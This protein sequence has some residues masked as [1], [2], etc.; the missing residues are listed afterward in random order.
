MESRCRGNDGVALSSGWNESRLFVR[1]AGSG[2]R[3]SETYRYF[4]LRLRRLDNARTKSLSV[5]LFRLFDCGKIVSA[6]VIGRCQSEKGYKEGRK[7]SAAARDH[8]LAPLMGLWTVNSCTS[9]YSFFFHFYT[10]TSYTVSPL[11]FELPAMQFFRQQHAIFPLFFS[12]SRTLCG[13]FRQSIAK[14]KAPTS[15]ACTH[16]STRLSVAL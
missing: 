3:S 2:Y 11:F 8:P 10:A 13:S 4:T 15:N 6:T 5:F 12:L 14:A 9:F 7:E 16:L 1:H